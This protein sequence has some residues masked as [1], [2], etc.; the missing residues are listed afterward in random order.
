MKN[1]KLI[2]PLA[3]T[4]LLGCSST[5]KAVGD[6]VNTLESLNGFILELNYSIAP[7]SSMTPKPS[8]QSMYGVGL[9]F[10]SNETFQMGVRGASTLPTSKYA[11]GYTIEA[12]TIDIEYS[13]WDVKMFVA[14]LFSLDQ[15]NSN[16]SPLLAVGYGRMRVD[17]L[18]YYSDTRE[19]LLENANLVLIE[20]GVSFNYVVNKSFVLSLGV[21]YQFTVLDR[22]LVNYSSKELNMLKFNVGIGFGLMQSSNSRWGGRRR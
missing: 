11:E 17:Q 5:I 12:D 20:P 1:N 2:I 21:S 8:P 3:L 9:S 18:D 19:Q 14:Y 15:I 22:L 16:V 10:I 6:G 13:S 4:L 7:I